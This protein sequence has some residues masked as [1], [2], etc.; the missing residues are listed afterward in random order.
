MMSYKIHVSKT[1]KIHV[2][3]CNVREVTPN[4]HSIVMEAFFNVSM[5]NYAAY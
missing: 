1:Y 2:Y 4:L 5:D 3:E